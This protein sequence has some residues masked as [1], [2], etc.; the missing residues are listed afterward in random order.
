M[1]AREA[2]EAVLHP[3]PADGAPWNHLPLVLALAFAV[4]AAVALSGDFVLH[5]D[6]IMQYL[7]PAHRLVFGAGITFWE[8]FYGARSWLVPGLV[9][10]VLA[11]FD[12]VG[13]GQPQWY[14]G[15]V[16]LT[17]CAISLAIPAGMYFFARHHFS[18]AA[19]RVALLAGAFW[20]ELAGFAH[21]P[22]TEFVATAALVPVL[23]LCV[24][25]AGLR[26]R[27]VW[28]V[29]G[30]AVLAAAVRL[31][32][33]PFA[34]VLLGVVF[35]RSQSKMRLALAAAGLVLAVGVFDAVT[36]DSGLF[37]SYVTN[38]RYNL[39]LGPLRAGESPPWQYLEW[40]A[41][42]GAGLAVP[43]V[44]LLRP[45]RY[46]FLLALIVLVIAIHSM[47]EHK[48]YR[49]VFVVVPLWLLIGA[50][51]VARAAE[52][53][54][55][56]HRLGSPERPGPEALDRESGAPGSRS[57]GSEQPQRVCSRWCP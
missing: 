54:P 32:Y 20:Y 11:L 4:R 53:G 14:V 6:E 52:F 5:P 57:A 24:R 51:M 26:E 33:A 29:A 42:A 30:L 44:A 50:D 37:H 46:A 25:P 55:R 12:T 23:A 2:L 34:L 1:R 7:E 19:A 35:L 48:E 31:Q 27:S 16:E 36:W 8:Y 49:F 10:G 18:E 39:V 56:A 43:C 13:L 17:F 41:I 28:P 38:V 47:Q 15:G 40:L 22:M 45:G 9:A 3:Q 21:K